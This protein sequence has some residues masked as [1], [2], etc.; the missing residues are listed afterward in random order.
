MEEC[1]VVFDVVEDVSKSM[2]ELAVEDCREGCR[3]LLCRD[4]CGMSVVAVGEAVS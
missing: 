3:G 4:I 2:G 1:F